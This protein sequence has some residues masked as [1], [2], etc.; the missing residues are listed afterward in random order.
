MKHENI[1]TEVQKMIVMDIRLDNFM[2]FE[3]F[4]MNMS[5]PKRIVDSYI[6]NEHLLGYPNFRYKKV[7][8]LMGPMLQV[9]HH[10]VR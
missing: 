3:N 1:Y 10:L 6:E 8:V 2:S 9:K 7:N 5:Y 4:H